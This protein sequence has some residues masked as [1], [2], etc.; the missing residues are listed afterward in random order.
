MTTWDQERALE[1]YN[2]KKRGMGRA[3]AWI[4]NWVSTREIV[5]PEQK[6]KFV[7]LH[8]DLDSGK[9]VGRVSCLSTR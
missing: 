6:V 3:K 2:N 5:G 1:Y 8:W 4:R 9:F 7:E